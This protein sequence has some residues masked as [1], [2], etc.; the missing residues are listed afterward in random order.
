MQFTMNRGRREKR[1]PFFVHVHELLLSCHGSFQFPPAPML[2]LRQVPREMTWMRSLRHITQ[3]KRDGHHRPLDR[4]EG[5]N[6]KTG[7]NGAPGRIRTSDLVLRRHTL[8][9]AEL[10]ARGMRPARVCWTRN[11]R[12]ECCCRRRGGLLGGMILPCFPGSSK[13]YRGAARRC[14]SGIIPVPNCHERTARTV[15]KNCG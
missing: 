11:P 2:P 4:Q 14:V 8:Y 6:H 7:K 12:R 3:S 13:I 15:G 1:R 5:N 9:P 10:R